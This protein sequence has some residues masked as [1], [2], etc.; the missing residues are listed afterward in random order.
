MFPRNF[1]HENREEG[2]IMVG[3]DRKY[4]HTGTAFIKRSLRRHE[5]TE[6]CGQPSAPSAAMPH[7]YRNDAAIVRYLRQHTDI[8]L[9]EVQCVFEDDGAVYL[10]S[11][12]IEGTV[13][14]GDLADAHR[15]VVEKELLRHV[16]TL[17][18]LRSNRP[19]VPGQSVMVPPQRVVGAEGWGFHAGWRGR[20]DL[21]GEF[22]FCHNDLGESSAVARAR[23]DELS[24]WSAQRLQAPS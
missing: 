21:V 6:L 14:M 7:R 12:F 1:L 15:R 19:G 17:K 22:V 11:T 2:C 20:D 13:N 18:T 24:A 10:V 23:A 3:P 9:P 16:A 4:Y 5:W 8:P